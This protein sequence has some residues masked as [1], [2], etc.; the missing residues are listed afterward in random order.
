ML[1]VVAVL[2]LAAL[3]ALR[4]ALRAPAV[5]QLAVLLL[6]VVV[7]VAVVLVVSRALWSPVVLLAA[8]AV[9]GVVVLLVSGSHCKLSAWCRW[10]RWQ[11]GV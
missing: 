2:L 11:C 1:V 10:L 9:L 6:A 5:V 3:A 4:V 8:V 7:V